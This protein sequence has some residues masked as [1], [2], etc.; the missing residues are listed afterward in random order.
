MERGI[1]SYFSND[2]FYRKIK[3]QWIIELEK[4]TWFWYDL[5][6]RP[7]DFAKDIN[8]K[9][10]II[11]YL[12]K[13]KKEVENNLEKRFIYFVC[14][15]EKVRF[16][17]NKKILYIPFIRKSII[18]VIIGNKKATLRIK[19]PSH[20]LFSNPI[21][22]CTDKFITIYSS[23]QRMVTYSI[24]DFLEKYNIN[25]GITSRIEYV[26]CTKNPH[27]RP[28]N[29]SHTGLNDILYNNIDTRDILIYFNTFRVYSKGGSNG[30]H[31]ITANAM[32]NE[33]DVE[34]EGNII[35]KS[36]ILYFDSEHQN[37]NKLNESNELKNE[38]KYLLNKNINSINFYYEIDG[39]ND[40]GFLSSS[41]VLP[42]HIHSFNI[43]YDNENININR[44]IK[45]N[46]NLY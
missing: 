19:F 35:E 24:H 41:K 17:T 34:K 1:F 27:T 2:E 40:Y 12:K 44:N 25:L 26:G 23:N 18:P 37:R 14:S 9:N 4:S 10:L 38:I 33:I 16:N 29:G 22:Y 45:F 28:T 7:Y 42:D 13:L 20:N 39:N 5:V 6:V 36:F 21:F 30:L 31:F 43:S 46:K 11:D 3:K 8:T 15:R 32:T